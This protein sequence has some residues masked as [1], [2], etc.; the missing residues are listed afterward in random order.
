MVFSYELFDAFAVYCLIGRAG[1][2][3]GELLVDWTTV[4]G[5]LTDGALAELLGDRRLEPGQIADQSPAWA[6][7]YRT[8]A[9]GLRR[10]LLITCDYGFR[11]GL[12]CSTRGCAGTGRSR[13]TRATS[14]AE[15]RSPTSGSATSPLTSTSRRCAEAG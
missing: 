4:E 1:G 12:P 2:E 13:A 5:D 3:V 15:T 14:S 9:R 11:A 6:P 7:L 8:L 10:G